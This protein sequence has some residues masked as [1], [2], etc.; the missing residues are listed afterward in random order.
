MLRLRYGARQSFPDLPV[1]DRPDREELSG[2]NKGCLRFFQKKIDLHE[3][4]M[5]IARNVDQS[6]LFT[7][8][9]VHDDHDMC[10]FY[11]GTRQPVHGRA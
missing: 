2:V 11:S 5:R 9:I 3:E 4:S 6:H 1:P 10:D 7:S 8:L